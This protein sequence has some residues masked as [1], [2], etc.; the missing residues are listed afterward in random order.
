MEKRKE[1]IEAWRAERRK[2]NNPVDPAVEIK[3]TTK[4]WSLEDDDEDE[5]TVPIPDDLKDDEMKEDSQDADVSMFY[6]FTFIFKF[7]T[8][9][10]SLSFKF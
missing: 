8:R 2:K 9:K 7:S 4:I 3:P 1:R 6:L 10:T 5:E